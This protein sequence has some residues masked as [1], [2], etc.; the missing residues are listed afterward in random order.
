VLTDV[1]ALTANDVWAIGYQFFFKEG[2]QGLAMH[3]N[4]ARW[5]EV[6]IPV[7]GDSYTLLNG[8]TVVSPTDV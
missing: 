6:A 2:Y 8:I 3:W 5:S 4:G 1:A 7:S